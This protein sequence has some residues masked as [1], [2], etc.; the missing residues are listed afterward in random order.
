MQLK[1]D[2]SDEIKKYASPLEIQELVSLHTGLHDTAQRAYD[3]KILGQDN[4][5]RQALSKID[6]YTMQLSSLLTT[7]KIITTS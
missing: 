4:E 6:K 3:L 5:A 7:L 1:N 2:S